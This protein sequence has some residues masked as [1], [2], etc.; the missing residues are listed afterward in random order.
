[1]V[2]TL[3]SQIS[4]PPHGVSPRH[5]LVPL[6]G[7]RLACQALP[8]ARVLARRFGATLRTI[9]VARTEDEAES[10][11]VDLAELHVELGN[12]RP[13]ILVGNDPAESITGLAEE[14]GSC[15]I[16]LTTRGRGR[17]RGAIV[18]SVARSVLERWADPIVALGPMADNPGS[19]P[20]PRSWPQPLSVSRVV[21]CVDGFS[22][23]EQ[24]LPV[25]SEWA[26]ALDMSLTILT[27]AEEEL[28]WV[29][30][31]RTGRRYEPQGDPDSYIG[32]LVDRWRGRAPAVDG[33]VFRDPIGL[34][35]G[36]RTYL[37]QR[38]AGLVAVSTH[39][40]SGMQRVRF[41]ASA[42]DIVHASVAP[43]LLVRVVDDTPAAPE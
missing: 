38:P 24:V 5:I 15:V 37:A 36:V 25:A 30:P 9:S 12:D 39:A 22:T 35:T 8:T 16:C 41:G 19:F 6:D 11:R 31:K 28:P 32:E 13:A 26:S 3:E 1:V 42:A 18:G 43:C 14:L 34:A 17:L 29:S 20:R 7:G 40:R 2:V 4:E 33:E 21:A 10:L 27:I 23:S